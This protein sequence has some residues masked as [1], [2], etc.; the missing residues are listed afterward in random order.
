MVLPLLLV[1]FYP[2]LISCCLLCV[3]QD[4]ISNIGSITVCIIRN[5]SDNRSF[6]IALWIKT[7]FS[8]LSIPSSDV[9]SAWNYASTLSILLQGQHKFIISFSLLFIFPQS[10]SSSRFIIFAQ[11][12]SINLLKPTGYVMHKQFNIQ[13]LYALP[14][15]NLCVLY[16]SENKQRFVSFTS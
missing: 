4:I 12:Q 15:L 6:V 10:L 2:H 7:D 1:L 3:F 5:T 8:L 14:T 13:Q 9:T 16:L 11:V